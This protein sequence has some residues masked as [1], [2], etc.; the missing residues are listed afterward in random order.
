MLT[1]L[2]LRYSISTVR[3]KIY[4]YYLYFILKISVSLPDLKFTFT[5]DI[6]ISQKLKNSA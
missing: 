4:I 6:K 5:T 1:N 3:L 2:K